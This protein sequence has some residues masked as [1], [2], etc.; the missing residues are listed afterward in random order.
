MDRVAGANGRLPE[1]Q[2]GL[3]VRSLLI[4]YFFRDKTVSF[5]WGQRGSQMN[6]MALSP[7]RK[8]S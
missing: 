7:E 5:L 6:L 3:W 2:E 4:I 1:T 8:E